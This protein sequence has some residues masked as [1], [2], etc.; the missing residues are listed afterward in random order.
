VIHAAESLVPEPRS[1]EVGF[2]IEK[3]K[4]YKSLGTDRIPTEMIYAR[5]KYGLRS[6]NLLIL[7]GI[8]NNCHN[9]ERKLSLHLFAEKVIKLD[10]NG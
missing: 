8:K 2:T 3:L 1:S 10:V 6:I 5:I 7:F 9:S 4:T